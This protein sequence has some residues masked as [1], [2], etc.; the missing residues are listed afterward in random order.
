LAAA[1]AVIAAGLHAQTVT[2]TGPASVTAGNSATLTATLAGSS[3]TGMGDLQW[4]FSL[5][6][7]VTL[8]SPTVSATYGTAGFTPYCGTATCLMMDLTALTV[9]TDGALL[10]IPV[11]IAG[12]VTPG[13]LTIPLTGIFAA[14]TTGLNINGLASGTAYTIKVYS[15]CD[16]NQDGAVNSADVQ[17]V[18]SAIVSGASCPITAANG[19]CTVVTAIDEVIAALGGACKIP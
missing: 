11:N 6:A 13:N 12:T 1:L 8:G 7:G 15:P 16:L 19:G 3:G 2:I 4:S 5:P 10:T 17:L 14:T 9:M 18:V